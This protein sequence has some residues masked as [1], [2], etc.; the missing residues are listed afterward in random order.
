MKRILLLT[1]CVLMLFAAG[2]AKPIEEPSVTP[3][4]TPSAAPSVM[5]TVEATPKPTPTPDTRPRSLTTGLVSEKEYAPMLVM[6]E[7]HKAARPQTGLQQADII[8]EAPVEG[9]ITRFACLFNDTYPVVAGPVR[10]ARLYYIHI[11]REWDAPYIHYGGPSASTGAPA[12]YGSQFDDI[13]LRVDGLKGKY[14]AYF[15]RNP[16][17]GNEHTVFTNL[18]KIADELYDYTP[19]ERTQFLFSEEVAYDGATVTKVGVPFHT[20]KASNTEFVYDAANDVF[21]RYQDGKLFETRTV[22]EDADGN[23]TTE[24][25]ALTVKNLVVQYANFYTFKGDSKGRRMVDV[26]GEGKCTYFIG[27]KQVEGKWSRPTMDDSTQYMLEDGTPVVL[28]PG[29]TWICLQP[30]S[31]T[32]TVE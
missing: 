12:V 29:N 14:N 6:I 10:S 4:S 18:Q 32:V 13:K 11:Q 30:D 26:V 21:T 15:W 23:Q 16:P 25:A 17:G 19:D 2:C 20:G 24:T 7:N 28:Q 27:G 8:Y 3:E 9:G 5:P 22:T 1:L 31:N